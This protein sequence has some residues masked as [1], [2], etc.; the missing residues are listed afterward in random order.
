[1]AG[2]GRSD[3]SLMAAAAAAVAESAAVE[4][5]LLSARFMLV[6]SSLDMDAACDKAEAGGPMEANSFP[7]V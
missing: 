1:M 3:R 4:S 5:I 2:E 6:W 7:A